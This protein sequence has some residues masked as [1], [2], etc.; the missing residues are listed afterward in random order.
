[1]IVSDD[2]L[3]NDIFFRNNLARDTTDPATP[4]SYPKSRDAVLATAATSTAALCFANSPS[5]N[6]IFSGF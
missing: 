2:P 1:M 4:V 5:F 6:D 3:H